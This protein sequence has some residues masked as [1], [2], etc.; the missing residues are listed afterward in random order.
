MVGDQPAEMGELALLIILPPVLS[1]VVSFW[2]AERSLVL[3]QIVWQIG[4]AAGVAIGVY[5]LQQ[6]E[7]VFVYALFPLMAMATIG[8]PGAIAAE[9]IAVLA[10]VALSHSPAIPLIPSFYIPAI[11]VAG[12]LTGTLGWAS[13]HPLLTA[14]D[15]YLFSYSQAQGIMASVREQRGKLARALKDLDLAYY[16]LQRKNEALIAARNAAEEAERSKAEFA[17]TVSHELRTPLNLIVGFSEMMLTAPESYGGVELPSVYRSDLNAICRSAQHILALVDDVLDLARIDVGKMPLRRER[18]TLI[19]LIDE[20]IDLVHDYVSAKGLELQVEVASDLPDLWV[21]RLRIRQVLL[22][23]LVNAVRFTEHGS[24]VVKVNACDQEVEIRVSDTGRGIQPEEL[25]Q[26]FEDFRAGETESS[27]WHG[28]T[29]LG[30]PISKRFV[31]LHGGRIGVESVYLHGSTF[32]FTLPVSPTKGIASELVRYDRLPW[33]PAMRRSL[34]R[35]VVVVNDDLRAVSLMERHMEGYHVLGSQDVADG[36][37]AAEATNAV[38]MIMN[39]NQPLPVCN[40]ETVVVTCPLPDSHQAAAAFGAKDLLVKPVSCQE[41]LTSVNRVAPEARCVLIVDDD[42]AMV[43][44]LRRM[45]RTRAVP[46][47]CLEAHNGEEALLLMR[48]EKPD[49]VLLDLAMPTLGG[50]EVL[51]QMASDEELTQ[52][53]A[54]IVSVTG[55]DDAG[56]KL[57]DTISISRAAGFELGEVVGIL[58]SALNVLTPGWTQWP[59]EPEHGGVSLG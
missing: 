17:A 16:R 57:T 22:N 54:I 9:L 41:L 29:G 3:A 45:L 50:R 8:W 39:S 4:L 2:L 59:M 10:V 6:P 15:W 7:F 11:A 35:V 53:P 5:V 1:C 55:Q 18:V 26:I 14:V 31:E 38:A 49:L 36:I 33:M 32:W 21:D 28:G 48:R 56:V 13:V 51:E 58:K 23:L 34:E 47:E 24:I 27:A 42:M 30:L 52:I 44:L 19:M 12:V 20:A 37:A 40:D 25:P 46:T 43:R